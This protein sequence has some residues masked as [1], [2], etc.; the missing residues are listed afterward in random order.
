MQPSQGVSEDFR[1]D[2]SVSARD[3]REAGQSDTPQE[4]SAPKPVVPAKVMLQT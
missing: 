2:N 4:A 1:A 3:G